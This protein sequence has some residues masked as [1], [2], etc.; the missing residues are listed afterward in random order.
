MVYNQIASLVNDMTNEY[1]GAEAVAL[2]DDLTNVVDVGNDIL[3]TMGFDIIGKAL[4]DRIGKTQMMERV[5]S[6]RFKSIYKDGWEFGSILQR[7]YIDEL[8]DAEQNESYLLE[9]GQVYETNKFVSIKFYAKYYNGKQT[10]DVPISIADRQ[11][12]SAFKSPSDLAA[13]VSFIKL[14]II[15]CNKLLLIF[16]ILKNSCL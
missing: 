8:P 12:R 1:I 7:V 3:N 6:P 10:F 4:V 13:F 11:L 14:S 15:S 5:Y 2:Q 9:D 16:S